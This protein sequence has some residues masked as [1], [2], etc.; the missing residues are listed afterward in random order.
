VCRPRSDGVPRESLD[1]PE[2]LPKEAPRQVAL[3]Q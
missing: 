1:T 2:I 3:G